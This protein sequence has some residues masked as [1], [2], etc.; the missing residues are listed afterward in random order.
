[1]DLMFTSRHMNLQGGYNTKTAS[2]F[3]ENVEIFR[4]EQTY[5]HY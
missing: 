4:K 3:V 1:M 2:K 5:I